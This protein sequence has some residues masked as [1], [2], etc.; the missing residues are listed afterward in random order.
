[1]SATPTSI[2]MARSAA[3]AALDKLAGDV[4][5]VDVS[6]PLVIVDCFVVCSAANERQLGAISEAIEER[7]RTHGHKPLRREGTPYTGWVLLDY[8]EIVVHIQHHE[9]REFYGLDRLW[10]D[11]PL[12]DCSAH[13]HDDASHVVEQ[14]LGG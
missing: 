2:E 8:G 3:Q 4:T 5:I 14:S 6:A 10:K 9:T 1:M 12:I 7:L 13:H 11:C